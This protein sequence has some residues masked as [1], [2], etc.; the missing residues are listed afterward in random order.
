MAPAGLRG[1]NRFEGAVRRG[2]QLDADFILRQ[3]PTA[4]DDHPHDSGL[5]YGRAVGRATKNGCFEAAL[6]TID[7]NA[8]VPQARD[9]DYSAVA[10][11]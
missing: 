6:E 3:H 7:L 5:A 10:D 2:R 8:R 9:F 11:P 4:H 1:L